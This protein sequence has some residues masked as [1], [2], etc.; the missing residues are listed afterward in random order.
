LIRRARWRTRLADLWWL[1]FGLGLAVFGLFMVLLA[2]GLFRPPTEDAAPGPKRI[3][4]WL[5]TGGV[6]MPVVV[7]VVVFGATPYAMRAVP[8]RASQEALV[9][10]VVGHRWWYEVHHPLPADREPLTGHGGNGRLKEF[11]GAVAFGGR[12]GDQGGEQRRQ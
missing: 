10:E 8:T 3:R 6:V 11:P 7:L 12:G 5:V 4:R 9:V 2:M 1:M